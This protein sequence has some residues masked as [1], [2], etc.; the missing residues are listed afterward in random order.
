M[1]ASVEV[2]CSEDGLFLGLVGKISLFRQFFLSEDREFPLFRPMHWEHIF[3]QISKGSA[4]NSY[5]SNNATRN[6]TNLSWRKFDGE[7]TLRVGIHKNFSEEEN[8]TKIENGV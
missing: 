4:N 7:I 2:A 3:P 8:S 5:T 1:D 6:P